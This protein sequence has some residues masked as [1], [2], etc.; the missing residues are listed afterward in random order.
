LIVTDRYTSSNAIHQG[1]KLSPEERVEYFA[2][3]ED[4]EFRRIGLPQADV[5]LY[6]RISAEISA[7]RI[8]ARGREKDI[9]ER[10]TDYL[11]RC[12]QSADAAAE[13]FGWYVID[14]SKKEDQIFQEVIQRCPIL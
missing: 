7:E 13:Y 2:W 12:A 9:H 3:L 6:F 4:Y 8:S 5:T 14:A 1:A 10:D 11:K